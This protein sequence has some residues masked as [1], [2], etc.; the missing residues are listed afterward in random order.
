MRIGVD[1]NVLVY[2]HMPSMSQHGAVRAHLL[3]RLEDSDTT[4]VLTPAILH[5]LIHVIT[6]ARRFD[7][8]VTMA[9]AIATARIYL[10][11]SNVEC[12]PIDAGA[13]TR[14]LS[15]M[16]SHQLGRKRAAD[17]LYAATLLQHEVHHLITCNARDF[18]T[19][20]EL[21]TIDPLAG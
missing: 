17:I 19:F 3:S 5:E 12:I 20:D 4:L 13:M 15:L 1:T 10:D 11:A 9:E 18:D 16:E 7:P 2:A 21:V 8:P 14:A 6:D